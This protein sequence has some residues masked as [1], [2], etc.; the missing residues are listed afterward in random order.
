MARQWAADDYVWR[1]VA[2][3]ISARIADG[4]YPLGSP[5]PPEDDLASEYSV[6]RSTVRRALRELRKRGLIQPLPGH[7]S[8]VVAMPGPG[9]LP[10]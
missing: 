7:G 10:G 1:Q 8:A 2:N 3:D 9:G 6:A 5:L 4:S